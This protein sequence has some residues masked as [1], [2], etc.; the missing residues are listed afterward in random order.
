MT[1]RNI[2]QSFHGPFVLLLLAIEL[3]VLFRFPLLVTLL[4]SSNLSYDTD[5]GFIKQSPAVFKGRP[6]VVSP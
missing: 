3:S 6:F 5:N 1:R 4:A 2:Y